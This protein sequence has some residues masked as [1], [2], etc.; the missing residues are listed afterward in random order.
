MLTGAESLGIAVSVLCR[1]SK[2]T[3]LALLTGYH[4]YTFVSVIFRISSYHQAGLTIAHVKHGL[5]ISFALIEGLTIISLLVLHAADLST[6][7]RGKVKPWEILI[8][9]TPIPG[10][11][12]GI[13]SSRSAAYRFSE[14]NI[15]SK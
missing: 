13:S 15:V 11:G 9:L 1:E 5:A 2:L 8:S 10:P 7:K 4:A 12:E 3:A 6:S 14:A